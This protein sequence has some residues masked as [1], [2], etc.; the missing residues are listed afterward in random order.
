MRSTSAVVAALAA[1]VAAAP[2]LKLT[3]T[4]PSVVTDVDNLTVK[5]IVTNTGAE[6][7]KLLKDPRTVLSDWR[8][9]TFAIEGAA[10]TPAFTGIKVKYSPELALKSGDESKFAVLAPGQSFELTHD[11]AGVYNFTR[12]GAV[13]CWKRLPIRRLNGQLAT[14]A[15]EAQSHK[16]KVGGS[17]AS[18]KGAPKHDK[19]GIA[20]RAIG[21]T[22]C[23][24]TRQSQ[25]ATAANSA[26]SYV[27]SA[28]SYLA[29][30]SSGTTR[31]TTWFGTFTSSRFSTVKSHYSLIGTDATSTTYDCTCTESG[32]YAYVYPSSPGYVYLCGAFW[33][34]PNTGTDSRAGTIVHEQSHFTVNGGTDD[35]VYGQSGAKSLAKSSPD[36]AIDNAD[37]HDIAPKTTLDIRDHAALSL[38]GSVPFVSPLLRLA[39]GATAVTEFAIRIVLLVHVEFTDTGL[40]LHAVTTCEPTRESTAYCNILGIT[41]TRRAFSPPCVRVAVPS[42]SL[43]VTGPLNVTDVDNLFVRTVVTNTGSDS[44]KLLKDPSSVLSDWQTNSFIIKS[45]IGTPLFTGIRI[46]YS[47][48]LALKSGDESNFVILASGE[49][50]ALAHSLAGV[51]N[52]TRSGAG[53]YNFSASNI[54][55]MIGGSLVALRHKEK[56]SRRAMLRR[57]IGYS[58]CSEAQKSQIST[59]ANFA[60]EYVANATAYLRSISTGTT[61]YTQWFGTFDSTRFG[62]VKLHFENI[63]TDAT[64]STYDCGCTQSATYAY[65]YQDRPGYVYLCEAFWSALD[66]GS[67]SRAGT[68][69]HEQS[70]FVVNGGTDD[71]VY[72]SASARL[73]AQSNPDQAIDNADNHEYFVENDPVLI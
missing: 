14:V 24:S 62:T 56:P 39:R 28:N 25:I 51:Y 41:I 16:L 47:P 12:S 10:G 3:V 6:T 55:N 33:N 32:T 73:L 46:K 34:A 72:G 21:Y 19:S 50:F 18:F 48:E 52:F 23:S 38:R 4:G 49:S 1:C 36:Q 35:H 54:S 29:G 43:T 13:L 69:V 22:S 63:G 59:A 15:A 11:L 64:S 53:E 17:L 68:I 70:H 30:I 7:V 27:S 2:S 42:L 37:N 60:N 65:V 5:A 26:N 45:R 8:T 66:V 58:G 71:H 31:Y 57:D 44:V 9:N 61:R 40:I 67:D 20:R